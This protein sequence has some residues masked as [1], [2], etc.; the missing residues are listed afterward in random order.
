MSLWSTAEAS[1]LNFLS[2]K[3]LILFFEERSLLFLIS[4]NALLYQIRKMI[5]K[6]YS[7]IEM[8]IS[9]CFPMLI[10]DQGYILFTER[11]SPMFHRIYVFIWISFFWKYNIMRMDK[12]HCL[13]WLFWIEYYSYSMREIWFSVRSFTSIAIPR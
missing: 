8:S 7:T 4:S 6:E 2:V 12:D 3:R 1:L 10:F 13:F 9:G 5:A 11:A